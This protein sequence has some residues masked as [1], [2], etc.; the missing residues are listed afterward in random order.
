M[1]RVTDRL[2]KDNIVEL[3]K[4]EYDTSQKSSLPSEIV[5]LSSE[6]KIYPKDHPLAS[7]TIEMRYMTAYDEDI[8]TNKSYI[9]QGIMLDKLLESII[10]TP[11][12][13]INDISDTDKDGLVIQARILAYGADYPVMV[14]DPVTNKDLERSVD[15]TKI[16]YK[17][18]N[19]NSDD[20]GEFSYQVTTD[21]TIKFSFI[22]KTIPNENE[23]V[24]M[25]L[26]NIITQVR[27]K[28]D[29]E[30]IKHFIRYEFLSKQAKQFRQ[31]IINNSPGVILEADFEG[32]D[33]ST[34]TAGFPLKADFFWF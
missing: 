5:K 14:T 13:N 8:L 15:L 26:L 27:D 20:N 28:R 1:A 18:F 32:E 24:S 10:T 16:K 2:S 17:P 4:Q 29:E 22:K 25:F 12:I 21:L 6:G 31:Y 19:L 9:Q 23:T 7:G 34:F 33:G 3:A 30:S 11:G